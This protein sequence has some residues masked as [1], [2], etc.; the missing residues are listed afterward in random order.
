MQA[1]A[2]DSQ[3]ATW[4]ATL[5]GVSQLAGA[6]WTSYT[7]AVGSPIRREKAWV[8]MISLQLL[9]DPRVWSCLTLSA[10]VLVS[11]NPFRTSVVICYPLPGQKEMHVSIYDTAGRLVRQLEAGVQ[12]SVCRDGWT[13]GREPAPVGVH[14][15]RIDGGEAELGGKLLLMR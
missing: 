9:S 5:G 14:F 1:I 11:P 3:N 7:T 4:F 6:T 12:R 2:F 10:G 13:S 8:T 15:Y